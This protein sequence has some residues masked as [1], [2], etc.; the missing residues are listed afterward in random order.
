MSNVCK[1]MQINDHVLISCLNETFD[2]KEYCEQHVNKHKF[3]KPDECIICMEVIYDN[4]ETPLECG[5][6]IHKNCIKFTG[7]HK[8]PVCQTVMTKEETDYVFGKDHKEL[9]KYNDGTSIYWNPE[10]HDE[11]A[12]NEF[13]HGSDDEYENE[14]NED[15]NEYDEYEDNDDYEYEDEDENENEYHRE[16]DASFPNINE[17]DEMTLLKHNCKKRQ[18][19]D[20]IILNLKYETMQTIVSDIQLMQLNSKYLKVPNALHYVPGDE[21]NQMTN[22]FDITVKRVLDD[23]YE[24]GIIGGDRY[25]YDKNV[26]ITTT[27]WHLYNM[28]EYRA[29][30]YFFWNACRC[31]RFDGECLR[32]LLCTLKAVLINFMDQM[33]RRHT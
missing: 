20:N 19:I 33:R 27:S 30:L 5:H 6:W 23:H 9:N 32:I 1:S 10:E 15:E 12:Y 3:E 14:D 31:P 16:D 4:I 24:S 25:I 22:F 21:W 2:N 17:E 18:D 26:C 29:L 13:G 7:L 11:Y 8:C 28:C